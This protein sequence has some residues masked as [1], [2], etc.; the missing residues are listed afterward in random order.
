MSSTRVNLVWIPSHCGI[1]GNVT[2]K[3][4]ANEGCSAPIKGH[5][6]NKINTSE[7]T[8]AFHLLWRRKTL[9]SIPGLS[10]N[11]AVTSRSKIFGPLPW[12]THENKQI[13]S[14]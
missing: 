13:Q 14:I 8:A 11:T 12:H 4:L 5:I 3:K 10:A 2:A 9:N 6:D 7:I 1:P